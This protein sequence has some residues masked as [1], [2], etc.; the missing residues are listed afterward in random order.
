MKVKLAKSKLTDP[1][2]RKVPKALYE[3]AQYAEKL[4]KQTNTRFVT[5][6]PTSK[7]K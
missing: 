3:A 7:K 2:M 6:K 4:A 5:R 1:D